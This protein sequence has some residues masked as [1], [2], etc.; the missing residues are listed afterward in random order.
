MYG[1]G[2]VSNHPEAGIAGS[3]PAKGTPERAGVA[4]PISELAFE[5]VRLSSDNLR[6]P[7]RGR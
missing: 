6:L 7:R 1:H 2:S 3:N 5:L 4:T